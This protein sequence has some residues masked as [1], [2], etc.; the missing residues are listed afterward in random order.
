MVIKECVT[1]IGRTWKQL[2]STGRG[3]MAP[4]RRKRLDEKSSALILVSH[5]IGGKVTELHF[6]Y[7]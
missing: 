4:G 6:P 5:F 1:H 3:N 2:R 7:P